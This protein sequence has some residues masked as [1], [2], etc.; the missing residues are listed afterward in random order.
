MILEILKWSALGAWVC[1]LAFMACCYVR[2][3]RIDDREDD[4]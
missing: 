3:P 1:A 2:A 4:R